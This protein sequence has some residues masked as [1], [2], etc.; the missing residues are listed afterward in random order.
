MVSDSPSSSPMMFIMGPSTP[1]TYTHLH[2]L[3]FP[4]YLAT[5]QT[6]PL[7]WFFTHTYTQKTHSHKASVKFSTFSIG[8]GPIIYYMLLVTSL[9]FPLLISP[10]SPPRPNIVFTVFITSLVLT[11]SVAS[12]DC[13]QPCVLHHKPNILLTLYLL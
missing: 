3:S 12:L 1:Y 9:A 6:E 8:R 5:L 10:L 2:H 11:A 7:H 4:P 13:Q